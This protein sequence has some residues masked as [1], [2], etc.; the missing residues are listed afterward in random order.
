MTETNA[1]VETKFKNTKPVEFNSIDGAYTFECPHC[2]MFIQVLKGETA[3]CIFRHATYKNT[4][5]QIGPH[6]SKAE[7]DRLVEGGLVDGCAKPFKF[8]DNNPPYV[9]VCDYI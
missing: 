6:T 5:Q 8:F 3:C 7:C 1:E 4:T 9:E 2:D